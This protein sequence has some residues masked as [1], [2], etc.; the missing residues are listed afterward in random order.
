[1]IE[2]GHAGGH[3]L[4]GLVY[5]GDG[6]G[7]EVAKLCEEDVACRRITVPM[8]MSTCWSIQ[9]MALTLVEVVVVAQRSLLWTHVVRLV[10]AE[11]GVD[12]QWS[13]YTSTRVSTSS[14]TPVG[15]GQADS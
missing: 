4:S 3:M 12:R 6:W 14:H 10:M 7:C 11:V 1:M 9:G 8:T 13:A 15:R 2:A 5:V